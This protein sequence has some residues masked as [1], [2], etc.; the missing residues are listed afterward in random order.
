MLSSAQEIPSPSF[1][2]HLLHRDAQPTLQIT[3][4]RMAECVP[5]IELVKVFAEAQLSKEDC[6]LVAAKFEI[7]TV[8]KFV[9][10]FDHADCKTPFRPQ[11]FDKKILSGK[12][13]SGRS[14]S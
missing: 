3:S 6:E 11:M 4:A 10:I 14:G 1:F 5:N 12:G 9:D 2:A 7:D 8:K 13:S